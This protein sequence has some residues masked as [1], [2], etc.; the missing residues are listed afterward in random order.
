M[1]RL[2]YAL[3][4]LLVAI[5]VSFG[6][7]VRA[8]GE[9]EAPDPLRDLAAA[10]LD[11]ESVDLVRQAGP[12]VEFPWNHRDTA[13][14]VEYR[15]RDGYDAD[16]GG[17]SGAW[18][19]VTVSPAVPLMADWRREGRPPG[20][21]PSRLLSA[22]TLERMSAEWLTA[23]F[24]AFSEQDTLKKT[25]PLEVEEPPIVLFDW[26]G[27]GPGD[28]THHVQIGLSRVD[29]A[30]CRFIAGF[31]A[32]A[33]PAATPIQISEEEARAIAETVVRER[34]GDAPFWVQP[35]GTDTAFAAWGQPVYAVLVHTGPLSPALFGVHATTGEVLDQVVPPQ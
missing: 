3:I 14:L 35:V 4:V 25:T 19:A 16:G 30:P 20:A 32:P 33:P 9:P 26:A 6:L 12:G 2:R 15:T 22:G 23:H 13:R 27:P 24:P 8:Q 18:V 31:R 17:L 7:W 1:R 29:G 34:F 10:F 5:A 11:V 28:L 21:D